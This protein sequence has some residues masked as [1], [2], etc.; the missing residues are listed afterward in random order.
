MRECGLSAIHRTVKALDGLGNKS[1]ADTAGT[2]LD[3]GD[4]AAAFYGSNL[5]EVGIPDS[6]RLIVG[7]TDIIAE[8]GAFSAYFTFS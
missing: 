3:G 1:G 2:D 4:A 7:M 8:T 5:L 6:T